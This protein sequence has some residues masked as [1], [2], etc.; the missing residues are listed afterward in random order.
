MWV[1]HLGVNL[2][3]KGFNALVGE[4]QDG[5]RRLEN[6]LPAKRRPSTIKRQVGSSGLE[7]GKDRDHECDGAFKADRHN[8]LGP[9][10]LVDKKTGELVGSRVKFGIGEALIPVNNRHSLGSLCGLPLE[11]LMN[12]TVKAFQAFATL[13]RL[14]LLTF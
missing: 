12:N 3:S 10:S 4:N 9:D 2:L 14:D 1:E 13:P 11:Q 5:L 6:R 7:H 8:S